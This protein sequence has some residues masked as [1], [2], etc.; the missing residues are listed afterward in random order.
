MFLYSYI[1]GNEINIDFSKNYTQ[2][3][4]MMIKKLDEFSKL[5]GE[6]PQVGD[7]D[8]GRFL[9][10]NNNYDIDSLNVDYFKSISNKLEFFD[11][12][13]L[14]VQSLIFNLDVF[15]G[16]IITFILFLLQ[17]K[18]GRAEMVDM[19]IMTC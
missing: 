17:V 14:N 16:K 3:L 8:S 19:R 4:K 6:I 12:S 10:F 13:I 11:N 2:R 5:N 7:N 18:K 1:V 9:V 15:F